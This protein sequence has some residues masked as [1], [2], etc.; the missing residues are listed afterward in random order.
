MLIKYWTVFK[1]ITQK[2][3]INRAL[4]NIEQKC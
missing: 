4:K 1:N 3:N 2:I